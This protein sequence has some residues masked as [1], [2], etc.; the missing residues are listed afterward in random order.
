MGVK[1]IESHEPFPKPATSQADE[2]CLQARWHEEV[3]GT[4]T[5]AGWLVKAEDFCKEHDLQPLP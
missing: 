3:R 1:Q 4:R 5:L 2:T